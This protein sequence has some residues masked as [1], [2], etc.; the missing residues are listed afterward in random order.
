MLSRS[1]EY[2]VRALSLLAVDGENQSLQSREIAARLGLPPQFLT[3]I[4]RRLTTT[5]L[6]ASQRGRSGGFR[7]T[8]PAESISL[9]DVVLPFEEAQTEIVCLLGQAYCSDQNACPLHRPLTEIRA[10]FYDLL[11]GTM[12]ADVAVRAVRGHGGVNP[13]SRDKIPGAAPILDDSIGGS[14]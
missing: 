2:A 5:G 14:G 3:K 13:A 1:S 10:R 8:R 12:L 7:L 6:V 11:E 9:L 4:L